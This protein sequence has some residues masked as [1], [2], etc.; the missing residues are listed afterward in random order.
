MLVTLSHISPLDAH[1]PKFLAIYIG[2]VDEVGD[3]MEIWESFSLAFQTVVRIR[4]V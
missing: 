1:L 2:N 4:T 3:A